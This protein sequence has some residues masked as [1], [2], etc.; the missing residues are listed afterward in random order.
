MFVRNS[1]DLTFVLYD[2]LQAYSSYHVLIVR[3][4]RMNMLA[5]CLLDTCRSW[6]VV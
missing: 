6:W 2:K 5:V 4:D 1:T 3:H